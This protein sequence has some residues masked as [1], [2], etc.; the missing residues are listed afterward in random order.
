MTEEEKEKFKQAEL[1]KKMCHKMIV[2]ILLNFIFIGVLFTFIYSTKNVNSFYYSTHITDIFNGYQNVACVQDLYTWLSED[3]LSN[4]IVDSSE[5]NS[6]IRSTY[7]N[8]TYFLNDA[9]SMVIG[10]PILRQLRTLKSMI[11]QF[12]LRFIYARDIL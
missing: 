11:K 5:Y 10:Y 4:L 1:R 8:F 12:H 6:T 2:E 3:F 9:A 7:S